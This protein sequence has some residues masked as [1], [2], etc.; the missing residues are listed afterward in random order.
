MKTIIYIHGA[1][2]SPLSFNYLAQRLPSHEIQF[3][4][5]A[6]FDRVADTIYK[7]VKDIE[8][9]GIDV[10]LIGHSLGGVIATN[11]SYASPFVKKI[12]AISSPHGGSEIAQ[13]LSWFHPR[14]PMLKEISP[15]GEAIAPVAKRGAIVPTM[16]VVSCGGSTPVFKQLND[17]V[18]TVESQRAL[19]NATAFEELDLN[20]FETLLSP[21]TVEIIT[22]FIFKENNEDERTEQHE[23]DVRS[24]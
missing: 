10:C 19:R 18:V 5:Y 17:G 13:R 14:Y 24:S 9:F 6:T 12:V 7:I 4:T 2:A 22:D 20:H 23:G 8:S 21:R 3:V 1:N 16:C 11:V 15:N